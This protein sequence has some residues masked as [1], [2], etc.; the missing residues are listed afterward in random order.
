MLFFQLLDGL[1]AH[2]AEIE[3]LARD[4]VVH[5]GFVGSRFFLAAS[6]AGSGSSAGCTRS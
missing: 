6:V 5:L 4:G 3:G 1:D 2:E